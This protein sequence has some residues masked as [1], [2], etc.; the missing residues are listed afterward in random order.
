M[1]FNR[2]HKISLEDMV[3]DTYKKFLWMKSIYSLF[4]LGKYVTIITIKGVDL[5]H[6]QDYGGMSDVRCS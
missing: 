1:E 2:F 6:R 5:P 3:I 4:S